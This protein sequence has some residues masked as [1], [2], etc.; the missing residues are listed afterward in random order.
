MSAL[1]NADIQET[2]TYEDTGTTESGI[3]ASSG[4][5]FLSDS[6]FRIEVAVSML[7]PSTQF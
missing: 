7:L 2:Q 3:S 4:H 1:G 5:H 6:E